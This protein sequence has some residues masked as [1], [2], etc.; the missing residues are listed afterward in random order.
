MALER[1]MEEQK[2][3]H[4]RETMER[5][6]TVSHVQVEYFARHEKLDGYHESKVTGQLFNCDRLM[7]QDNMFGT[8][9][10][11]YNPNRGR[12]FLFANMKT[13]RYDTVASRYQKEMTETMKKSLL[14][15]ENA[16]RAYLSKRWENAAVL[17]EKRDNM[18]WS[19]RTIRT[20]LKRANADSLQKT[21]P[22]F[23]K[24]EELQEWKDI[25]E[26]QKELQ[27]DIR[28]IRD[29]QATEETAENMTERRQQE[30]QLRLFRR[31][32]LENLTTENLLQAIITRKNTAAKGFFRR[33][34]YSFDYQK[35]DIEAYYREK[36]KASDKITEHGDTETEPEDEE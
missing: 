19:K 3:D 32:A 23:S 24:E 10:L 1:S 5:I 6:T 33:L 34:N 9:Q 30:E 22:F 35:K 14:K 20:Y 26:K 31:E 21:M 7:K 16:N 13:S 11:G 15:G 28:E 18:P 36:K 2:M 8:L 17:I 29:R 4:F 25:K 12:V 27:A